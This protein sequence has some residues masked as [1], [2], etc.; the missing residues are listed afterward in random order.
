MTEQSLISNIVAAFDD[1]SAA[2]L[3]EGLAWYAEA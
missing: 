1:A 3:T 2:D